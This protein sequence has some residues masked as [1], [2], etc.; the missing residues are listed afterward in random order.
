[1]HLFNIYLDISLSSAYQLTGLS[2]PAVTCSKLT[3][4]ILD[5]GMKYVHN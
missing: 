3:K 1:M 4:E 5:Q 2:Q